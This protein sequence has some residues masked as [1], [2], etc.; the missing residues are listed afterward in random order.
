MRRKLFRWFGKDE[1]MLLMACM[2]LIYILVHIVFANH[3]R[4][5]ISLEEKI[6]IGIGLV[7]SLLWI[8][9]EVINITKIGYN[10]LIDR[11][12]K[13]VE[14]EDVQETALNRIIRNGDNI[15]DLFICRKEQIE[16]E[17]KQIENTY[18]IS[19]NILNSKKEMDEYVTDYKIQNYYK[20]YKNLNL[21]QLEEFKNLIDCQINNI[22]SFMD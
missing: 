1:I 7:G 20:N 13:G 9:L 4:G 14:F 3:F 12:E 5:D 21:T 17:M 22:K 2:L 10:D 16:K 19:M 8:R 15:N 18:P 11:I 6:L